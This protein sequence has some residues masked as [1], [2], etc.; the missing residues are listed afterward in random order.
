MEVLAVSPGHNA[1]ACFNLHMPNLR[2][3]QGLNLSLDQSQLYNPLSSRSF[4]VMLQ[5][6]TSSVVGRPSRSK[7]V[8]VMVPF[9]LL[10]EGLRPDLTCAAV[11]ALA[12]WLDP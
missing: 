10:V 2:Y 1:N 12:A 11:S 9:E 4:G 3:I 8:A 5:H 6:L 7:T